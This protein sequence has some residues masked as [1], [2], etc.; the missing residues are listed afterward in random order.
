MAADD[1][2][3]S[4]RP[5]SGAAGWLMVLIGGWGGDLVVRWVDAAGR[6]DRELALERSPT[7]RRFVER[8]ATLP[9]ELSAL[10]PR[11]LRRLP[12]IGA[13]RALAIAEARWRRDRALGP[14]RIDDVPGIGPRTLARIEAAVARQPDGASASPS[15]PRPG[16]GS[17]SDRS[18]AASRG[19]ALPV[20][21]R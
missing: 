13:K 3:A 5:G 4:S 16:R 10:G 17:R 7:E 2:R 19:A 14:L 21:P 6:A 1:V 12:G 9:P 18:S 8:D 11:E 20:E 15:T